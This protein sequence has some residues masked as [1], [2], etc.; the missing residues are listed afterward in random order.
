[1]ICGVGT[2]IL[3]PMW[4]SLQTYSWLLHVYCQRIEPRGQES[5]PLTRKQGSIQLYAFGPEATQLNPA[6]GLTDLRL[7]RGPLDCTEAGLAWCSCYLE[8]QTQ[9]SCMW[10]GNGGICGCQNNGEALLGCRPRMLVNLQCTRLS[11]SVKN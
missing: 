10:A 4:S 11:H 3:L 7:P 2:A 6:E 9:P 5:P 8:R 1:M